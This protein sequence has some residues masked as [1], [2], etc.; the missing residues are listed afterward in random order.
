MCGVHTQHTPVW[1]K[2]G[3][4]RAVQV[5]DRAAEDLG[6][7]FGELRPDQILYVNPCEGMP[8]ERILEITGGR[9]LVLVADG[10]APLLL[11]S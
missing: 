2:M 7:Y 3:A 9:R 8:M 11:D 4:L 6:R 5:N 10:L 1:R